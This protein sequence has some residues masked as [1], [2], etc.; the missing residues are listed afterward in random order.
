[1]RIDDNLR[2]FGAGVGAVCERALV[3]PEKR[4]RWTIIANAKAGGFT[5]KPRWEKHQ[6]ELAQAVQLASANPRRKDA[7]PSDIC[8]KDGV[9]L[10][11]ETGCAKRI[12]EDLIAEMLSQP[13]IFHLIITAGGDGTSLEVLSALY[14]APPEIRNQCAVLRLPL[15]TGNDGADAWELGN[16]LSRLILPADI[17]LTRGLRLS[18]INKNKGSFPAF[19]ILSIGLDAFVTHHTNKMKDKMPG[20]SYKLWVNLASVFYDKLYDV[21]PMYIRA[22]DE[23]GKE[24]L[25]LHETPLL[26][27]MGA[28]GKRTYGSHKRVLPDE[29]NVCMARQMSLRRKIA[30]KEKLAA[31]THTNEPEIMMFSAHRVEF[32]GAYP[33]LA[34]MD[35]E[36]ILLKK[37]DFPCSITLTEP[38][39]PVLKPFEGE[40]SGH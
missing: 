6:S 13:D 39:I 24:T 12:A 15:G 16:A 7:R 17:T 23:E 21:G 26:L 38:A 14:N 36:T 3:A 40:M 10:T 5:I 2:D 28:S 30:L 29:R 33:I 1:M 35:G 34:Q 32:H 20:D 18:T 27:A 19:N 9:R 37:E 31:G 25:S 4:L 8:G 11:E 22:F